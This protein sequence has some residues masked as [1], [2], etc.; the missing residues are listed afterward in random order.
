[1]NEMNPRRD[2]RWSADDGTTLVG[3]LQL[4]ECDADQR[5]PAVLLISG[6]GPVDRDSNMAG[7]ATDISK[8]LAR[9]LA[10]MGVATLRFDKRGTG[11]SGGDHA[12][13]GFHTEFADARSALAH[14]TGL[15]EIDAGCVGVVGHSVGATMAMRLAASEPTVSAAVFLAGA[16]SPG[17]EV[18]EW[19][20]DRIAQ[21]LPGPDWL[22][23][24]LFRWIQRRSRAKLL[25]PET[26][27]STSGGVTMSGQW[28]REYTAHD[29]AADLARITCP[30]LAITGGK[31]LQ[32]DPAELAVIADTVAGPCRTDAPRDLTHVLRSTPDRPSIFQYRKLLESPVDAALLTSV[33]EWLSGTL[34]S[35]DSSER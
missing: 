32:V 17:A 23:G 19:Q 12:T 18:V 15:D 27:S 24:R 34:G 8:T 7:Q 31:D 21:T 25:R 22:T 30:V 26:E 35:E 10:D 14:L 9:H 5:R 28:F 2:E 16:S 29:P 33:G 11:S 4:P 20:S 1:M 13:T 3:T 6:S